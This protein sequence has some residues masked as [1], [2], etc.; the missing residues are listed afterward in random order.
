[1]RACKCGG[2]I[3]KGKRLVGYYMCL[4]CKRVYHKAALQ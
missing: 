3:K 4:T 1:M 2:E